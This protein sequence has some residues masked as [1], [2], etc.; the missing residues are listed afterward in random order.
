GEEARDLVGGAQLVG[1]VRV[2]V[3]VGD[4]VDEGGVGVGAV[5]QHQVTAGGQRGEQAF[6]DAV[7]VV[8]VG[9]LP[10]DAEHH[11]GDGPGEVEGAGGPGEDRVGVADVGVE[12][13]GGARRRA[14]EQRAGVHEHDG[15][16]VHVHDA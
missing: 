7:R 1:V 13:V 3:V 16:V 6:D 11:D 8:G 15:V 12:V 2:L 14:G 9:H 5:A 10:G 4:R